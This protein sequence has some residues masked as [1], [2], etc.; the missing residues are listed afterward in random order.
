MLAAAGKDDYTS[1]CVIAKG[2]YRVFELGEVLV[3]EGVGFFRPVEV[4]VGDMSPVFEVQVLIVH[5]A[6]LAQ[7]P[8][9][10]SAIKIA[11]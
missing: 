2:Q 11:Q 9:N 5:A 4:N 3:I 10:N 8:V 6:M 7:A 1:L